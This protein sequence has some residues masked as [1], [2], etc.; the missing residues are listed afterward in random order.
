MGAA[1]GMQLFCVYAK[2][3][4]TRRQQTSRRN[5]RGKARQLPR[6]Q[7]VEGTSSPRRQS[8]MLL[9]MNAPKQ[10]DRALRP[11]MQ[12][13]GE[14]MGSFSFCHRTSRGSGCASRPRGA[15]TLDHLVRLIIVFLAYHPREVFVLSASQIQSGCRVLLICRVRDTAGQFP[16]DTA[17]A[18]SPAEQ[19]QTSGI[20]PIALR[21]QILAARIVWQRQVCRARC[22]RQ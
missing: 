8:S 22:T 11:R 14:C 17:D 1:E 5:P 20:E 3:G 15:N 7:Q 18:V 4:G 10:P 6:R 2:H 21:H 9:G 16:D 12:S 13:Q 19:T